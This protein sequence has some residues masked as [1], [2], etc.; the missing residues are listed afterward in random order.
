MWNMTTY[1]KT[2]FCSKIVYK[3]QKKSLEVGTKTFLRLTR[4]WNSFLAMWRRL[5]TTR[6]PTDNAAQNQ[7]TLCIVFLF[8]NVLSEILLFVSEH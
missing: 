3:H 6:Y 1:N 5:P 2:Y 8:V 4:K 7:R